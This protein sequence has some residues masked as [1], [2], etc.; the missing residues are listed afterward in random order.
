M[1]AISCKELLEFEKDK[2]EKEQ[3]TLKDKERGALVSP[4]NGKEGI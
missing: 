4:E 2:K 3:R 1:H